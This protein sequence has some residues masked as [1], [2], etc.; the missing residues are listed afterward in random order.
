MFE[1]HTFVAS[2]TN[3]KSPTA[4]KTVER[5]QAE[6]HCSGWPQA[7]RLQDEEHRSTLAEASI[8]ATVLGFV[9]ARGLVAPVLG[10]AFAFAFG[11]SFFLLLFRF[12]QK[13]FVLLQSCFS[14]LFVVATHKITSQKKKNKC[15]LLLLLPPLG[16][17]KW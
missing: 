14:L 12:L 2:H 9:F 1:T 17:K 8:Q 15:L 7:A 10:F 13:N 6:K 16:V 11:F 3:N 5:T 4:I